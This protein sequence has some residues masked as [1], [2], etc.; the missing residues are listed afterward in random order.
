MTTLQQK[1]AEAEQQLAA[2]Q[3]RFEAVRQAAVAK[4]CKEEA[5]KLRVENVS[6]RSEVELLRRNLVLAETKNGG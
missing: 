4:A 2:V 5:D 1:V 3:A 6:L